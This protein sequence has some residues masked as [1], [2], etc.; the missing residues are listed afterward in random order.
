MKKLERL[1][2]LRIRAEEALRKRIS[3]YRGDAGEKEGRSEGKLDRSHIELMLENESLRRKMSRL[4][5][6]LDVYHDLYRDAPMAY[7]NFDK[8]G[9]IHLF[10]KAASVLLPASQS[11]ARPFSIFQLATQASLNDLRDLV[12]KAFRTGSEQAGYLELHRPGSDPGHYKVILQTAPEEQT[13]KMTGKMMISHFPDQESYYRNALRKKEKEFNELMGNISEGLFFTEKGMLES[14]NSSFTRMLGYAENELTGT[15]AWDLVTDHH[16]EELRGILLNPSG[17][18]GTAS[19]MRCVRKDGSV[20]WAEVKVRRLSHGHRALG[21]IS[22]IT[23]RKLWENQMKDSERQLMRSNAAKD[24]LFSIISHDLKTPFNTL[25][26]YTYL[27]MKDYSH[28]DAAKRETM[29]KSLYD[30]TK[31]TFNM[32]ENILV[33]SRSQTGGIPFA[34]RGVNLSGLLAE[35]I[36]LYGPTARAKSISLEMANDAAGLKVFADPDMVQTVIRNLVTNAIKFTPEKGKVTI[37]T[38][39]D[40]EEKVTVFV[41]DNGVGIDPDK[42]SN[43]FHIDNSFTTRGTNDEK[44]TGLGLTVCR[45]FIEKNGGEIWADSTP[46]KG[47]TFYFTLYKKVDAVE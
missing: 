12:E 33:W 24:K 21:S 38:I 7:V 44:G 31:Q 5:A 27:L 42:T 32:L 34:P 10:N 37:G 1:D 30:V 40:E 29:I 45:E 19:D 14:V 28:Y 17:S 2:E 36:R 43:L 8:D 26:G 41:R 47:S 15:P 4:E 9:L 39:D 16:R 23:Q 13:G 11:S 18:E 25:M 46:G 3:G 35:N 6:E 20:F 22:D